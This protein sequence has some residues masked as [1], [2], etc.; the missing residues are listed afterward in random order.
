VHC[1]ACIQAC[2]YGAIEDYE[3]RDRK[4]HLIKTVARVNEGVCQG[5]GTCVAICRSGCIDLDGFTD[6]QVFSE[7]ATLE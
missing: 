5:C 7:I 3:I 4:G 6:E 1:R 2:P